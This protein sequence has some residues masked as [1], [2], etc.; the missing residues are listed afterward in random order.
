MWQWAGTR[1]IYVNRLVSAVDENEAEATYMQTK[2]KTLSEGSMTPTFVRPWQIN[3]P[4]MGVMMSFAAAREKM[5][6]SGSVRHRFIGTL[7]LANAEPKQIKPRGT[8][9]ALINVAAS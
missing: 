6:P 7:S 2:R 1:R 9:A 4:N 3:T 5:A 8:E